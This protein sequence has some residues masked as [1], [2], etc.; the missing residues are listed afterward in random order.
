MGDHPMRVLAGAD[1]LGRVVRTYLVE[2]FWPGVTEAEHADAAG[3]AEAVARELRSGGRAID[4]LDTLLVPGDETAFFR[5]ASSSREQ[6]ELASTRARLPFDRVI[7]Y[8][9]APR[10]V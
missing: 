6:V 4:F 1:I 8:V 7:E 9:E 5:F 10:D 2:C 3:R